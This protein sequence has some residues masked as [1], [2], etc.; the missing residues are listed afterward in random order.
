MKKGIEWKFKFEALL[1]YYWK[2]LGKSCI[3]LWYLKKMNM[4][5]IAKDGQNIKELFIQTNFWIDCSEYCSPPS[6]N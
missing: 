4:K 2:G 6:F 5:K 3:K 1:K